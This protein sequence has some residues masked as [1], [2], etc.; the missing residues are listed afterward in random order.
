M[1]TQNSVMECPRSMV[2]RVIGKSGETVK[3]LQTY[4]G[5]TIQIDQSVD[6]TRV[7]IS[8]AAYSVNLAVSIITDIIRGSFKGFALLRQATRPA[9]GRNGY[10][11]FTEPRPVYAPGYGLIPA[12]QLY[13][14]RT[15]PPPMGTPYGLRPA[16]SLQHV[17]PLMT[18]SLPTQSVLTLPSD[19]ALAQQGTTM[20]LVNAQLQQLAMPAGDISG[21]SGAGGGMQY[22]EAAY[23]PV[24]PMGAGGGHGGQGGAGL[25]MSQMGQMGQM[26]Q[27]GQMG[28][29]EDF[30]MSASHRLIQAAGGGRGPMRPKNWLG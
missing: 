18:T 11:A 27:M 6:P 7:S 30:A 25:Q 24:L 4:T 12:S 8:G 10:P 29:S 13:D 19:A 22:G 9:N 5:A 28:T 23:M 15:A 1:R 2:G 16:D 14:D 17:Y 21:L 20:S 3:A 26:S